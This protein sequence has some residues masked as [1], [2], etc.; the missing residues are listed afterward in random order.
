MKE[1]IKALEAFAYAEASSGSEIPG[2][3]LVDKRATRKWAQDDGETQ[4]ALFNMDLHDQDIYEAP[5]LRSP[6]QIEK[7][8]GKSKKA[9]AALEPLVK[10]VSSGTVLVSMAD[11]RSPVKLISAED[12]DIVEGS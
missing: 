8:I 7:T 1:R 3:K 5:I 2:F 4:T 10:K 12:F 9:K 6:A 11:D